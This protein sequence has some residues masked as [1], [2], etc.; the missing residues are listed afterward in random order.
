M[1]RAQDA[2][3]RSACVAAL[4]E[5][6]FSRVVGWCLRLTDDE[7]EALDVAQDVF[8]RVERTLD[9][10]RHDSRFTTWL[11][12]IARRTSIDALRRRR[13]VE[14]HTVA[15]LNE[16][17]DTGDSLDRQL[18]VSADEQ[19]LRVTLRRLLAPDEAQVVYMHFSLGMTLPAITNSL[20][21]TNASGAKAPLVAAMRKLRRH[22][23]VAH[24]ATRSTL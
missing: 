20:G 10:F 24:G 3:K 17:E 23:N 4:Y 14:D 6:H 9:S 22:Y 19:R 7:Q 1:R 5:R 11:Y 8:M 18:D 16:P 21:L 13:R 15:L 12:V 2:T